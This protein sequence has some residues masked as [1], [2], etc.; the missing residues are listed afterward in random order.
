MT[1]KYSRTMAQPNMTPNPR[2]HKC[3]NWI[4]KD[5]STYSVRLSNMMDATRQD[6]LQEVIL[7]L[8]QY[9]APNQ[10]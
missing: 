10:E 1:T 6:L 5:K 7:H 8:I 9:T 3:P 4:P 2:D